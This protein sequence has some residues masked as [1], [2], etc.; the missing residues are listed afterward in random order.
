MSTQ[1]YNHWAKG[2]EN[3]DLLMATEKVIRDT[4]IPIKKEAFNRV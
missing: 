4:V 2:F 3:A 1:S